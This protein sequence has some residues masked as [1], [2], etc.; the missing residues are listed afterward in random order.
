MRGVP[1]GDKDMPEGGPQILEGLPHRIDAIP[2][3]HH[4]S[5]SFIHEK[6][7]IRVL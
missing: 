6:V 5:L 3:I 7:D 4:G 2:G 1:V